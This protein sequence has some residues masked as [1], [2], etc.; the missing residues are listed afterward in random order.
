MMAAPTLQVR[1][2]VVSTDRDL[3]PGALDPTD[4]WQPQEA[5]Q[6]KELGEHGDVW[7]HVW[8]AKQTSWDRGGPSMALHETLNEYPELFDGRHPDLQQLGDLVGH[9]L[10]HEAASASGATA[11]P[12]RK[13]KKALVP[14]CGRGY[15]AVLLAYV[16]GYDVYAL[17]IS[18]EALVQANAYLSGLQ[19]AFSGLS[20]G[21]DNFPFWVANRAKDPGHVKYVLGD[22]F[23]DQWM[24]DVDVEGETFDLIFDYT[25]SPSNPHPRIQQK[26][27]MWD[28]GRWTI[29]RNTQWRHDMLTPGQVLLR[30]PTH[31]TAKVGG[32]DAAAP[33]PPGREARVPRVPDGQAA[34]GGRPPLRRGVLVLP[35][36]PGPPG[37]RRRRQVRGREGP[38]LLYGGAGARSRRGRGRPLWRR[39]RRRRRR[40]CH[41][42][43]VQ[44]Q[45]DSRGGPERRWQVRQGL[46]FR[47]GP[48]PRSSGLLGT[49]GP[50]G[51]GELAESHCLPAVEV[52]DTVQ[53]RSC[54]SCGK[55]PG[56]M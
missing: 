49:E 33:R 18:K 39:R 11:P 5:F 2:K 13:R 19:E 29:S 10:G 16:F 14:A 45:G 55:Y 38:R 50:G 8:K 35:A 36:A 12:E 32:T 20:Q 1:S 17:D 26:K 56:S 53:D 51:P 47:V 28:R 22:F 4:C 54:R 30:H 52:E 31:S 41:A 37:R 21:P 44:A 40:T 27:A 24:K 9:G 23:T 15:D 6:G 34:E 43:T 3:S 7:D 42:G 48:A 25:V 46:G